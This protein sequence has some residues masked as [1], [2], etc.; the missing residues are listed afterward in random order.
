MEAGVECACVAEMSMRSEGMP[1]L[2]A[3]I[4]FASSR[5]SRPI[6]QLSTT[7]MAISVLP[8]VAT[9]ARAWMR[10]VSLSTYRLSMPPLTSTGSL[11][12]VMSI[13]DAPALN[14]A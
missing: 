9:M 7:T 14:S 12:G 5:N 1:V 8:S 3:A 6:M 10:V 2:A 11:G 4:F 13:T